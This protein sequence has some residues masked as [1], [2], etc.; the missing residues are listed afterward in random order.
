MEGYLETRR[1][2]VKGRPSVVR[3]GLAVTS[4]G[5]AAFGKSLDALDMVSANVLQIGLLRFLEVL[6]DCRRALRLHPLPHPIEDRRWVQSQRKEIDQ[7][8]GIPAPTGFALIR[9]QRYLEEWH[10]SPPDSPALAGVKPNLPF[11]I[12]VVKRWKR[13]NQK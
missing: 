4:G 10:T 7:F 6:A 9:S 11:R 13:L 12:K 8:E 1:P 2:P 3:G 5:L